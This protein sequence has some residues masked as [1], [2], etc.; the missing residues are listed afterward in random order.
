MARPPTATSKVSALTDE[1][2]DDF[3]LHPL[4]CGKP[5]SLVRIAPGRIGVRV[6]LPNGDRALIPM[7][8][9]ATLRTLLRP[10]YF[11]RLPPGENP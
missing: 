10:P 8:E 5:H 7:R 4:P 3:P 1:R 9:S 6:V 2:P 11:L